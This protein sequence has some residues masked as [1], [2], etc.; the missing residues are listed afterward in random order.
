MPNFG[1]LL[2][3]KSESV[4]QIEALIFGLF[5]ILFYVGQAL[6]FPP[7][8]THP[9]QFRFNSFMT[10]I[11]NSFFFGWQFD[12]L[13]DDSATNISL[14]HLHFLGGIIMGSSLPS[15][16]S[17]PATLISRENRKV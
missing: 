4:G 7:F 16:P 10:A 15:Y 9:F 12:Q 2:A 8:R 13:G 1:Q 14:R 17:T 11:Q 5:G 3:R 6:D